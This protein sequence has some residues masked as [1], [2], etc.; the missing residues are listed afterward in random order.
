MSPL[1]TQEES[2]PVVVFGRFTRGEKYFLLEAG[3]TTPFSSKINNYWNF[4]P[5]IQ[6]GLN[7]Q[8]NS[9]NKLNKQ[10]IFPSSE[11]CD[12]AETWQYTTVI[13]GVNYISP[14][15]KFPHKHRVTE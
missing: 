2:N 6:T 8:D 14:C 3:L 9:R 13:T 15:D 12:P 11:K 4:V 7:Q 10:A 1:N 5:N